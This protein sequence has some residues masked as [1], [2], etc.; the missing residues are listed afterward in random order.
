MIVVI[1]LAA[2]TVV[3]LS[4]LGSRSWEDALTGLVLAVALLWTYRRVMF[5]SPLVSS[6]EIL[7][8]AIQT[9]GFVI[10][11]FLDVVSGTWQV[12][13]YVLGIRQL[14]HPGILRIEYDEESRVRLGI[15]LLAMTMSPGSFVVDVDEVEKFAL[16][17]FIDIS[18][19]DAVREK[20][21]R[22]YFAVPGT[23]SL[24]VEALRHA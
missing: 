6:R 22:T 4:V 12:A 2:L 14:A 10:R 20:V 7:V 9:P 23:T 17:H 13:T 24:K 11:Y 18:D 8:T 5:P 16:V 19:P 15:A 21:L 3:Y 1:Q